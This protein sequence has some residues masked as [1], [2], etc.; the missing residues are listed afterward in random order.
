MASAEVDLLNRGVAALNNGDLLESEAL[1]RRL[2]RSSTLGGQAL[3]GIGMV[4][5]R[6]GDRVAAK[7]LF[8]SALERGPDADALYGLGVLAEGDGD[9]Q[10]AFNYQLGAIQLNPGHT[11]AKVRLEALQ[12][13]AFSTP[14]PTPSRQVFAAPPPTSAV[15]SGVGAYELILSGDAQRARDQAIAFLKRFHM[16]RRPRFSAYLGSILTMM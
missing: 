12:R 5:V 13:L 2:L 3:A 15:G 1:F 7:E 16:K 4:R 9:N 11:P 6:Q 10:Q 14:P 8:Q